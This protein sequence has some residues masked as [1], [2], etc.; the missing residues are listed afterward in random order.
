MSPSIDY[1]SLPRQYTLT[2]EVKLT[3]L[4]NQFREPDE[5]ISSDDPGKMM[6]Q[7]V[8]KLT[9]PMMQPA[10]FYPGQH[11]G[12]DFRKAATVTV[13]SFA[14]LAKI[15]EQFDELTR[16]IEAERP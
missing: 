5:P 7:M 9:A 10:A 8:G 13:S 1:R 11:A 2:V 3:E 15:I 6:A 16:Q 4:P 14:A 12:F